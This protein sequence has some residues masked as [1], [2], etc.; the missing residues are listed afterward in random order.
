[1]R[2]LLITWACNVAALWA[3]TELVG[4]VRVE[5]DRWLTLV[6]AALVFSVANLFVRPLVTLLAIPLI[7][8]TLGIALFFVNL[9]MLFLTS[10]LVGGF[11][12]DGFWAGVW[13]TIVV[14][15]VNALLGALLD[16]HREPS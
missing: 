10:W 15:A 6:V 7:I 3:A 1:M 11:E 2:R 8:L 16:R 14:W 12:I 4:G 9:L 13:A 5:D